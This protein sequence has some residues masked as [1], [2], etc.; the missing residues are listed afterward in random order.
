MRCKHHTVYL[1]MRIEVAMP[2][3][4]TGE[5]AF[6]IGHWYIGIHRSGKGLGAFI[7]RVSAAYPYQRFTYRL[8]IDLRGVA[9]WRG[10]PY[11][12]RRL[13]WPSGWW[14]RNL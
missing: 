10:W 14:W 6:R 4:N 12:R 2:W 5:L 1:P 11:Q 8:V 3:N 13:M 7:S 9:F